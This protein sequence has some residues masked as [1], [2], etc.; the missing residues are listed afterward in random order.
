MTEQTQTQTPPLATLAING[1]INGKTSNGLAANG[2]AHM[3][4]SSS[5]QQQQQQH[6]DQ[7]QPSGTSAED[8][9]PAKSKR[10]PRGGFD[11]TELPDAPPGYTVRFTF[12]SA[13]NLA[14]G[15]LHT[16]SS[17]PFL[18][19]TLK[20]NGLKRHKED[21]D[22]THRTRT[23]CRTLEPVWDEAWTVANVPPTG[24]TLKCRLY[25]E[26]S[27]DK[28]DR[29]GNV[30]VR[31]PR[32]FRSWEGFPPPGRTFEG[33]KR[34][35]S[36]RAYLLKAVTDRFHRNHSAKH[37]SPL[38]TISIELLGESEPPHGQMYTVGPARW[39][40]H[41]SPM[42]GRLAGTKVEGDKGGA[43]A[44]AGGESA[45]KKKQQ[46]Q[47]TNGEANGGEASS[48]G[49]Q[50]NKNQRY[51]FRA[52]EMQ[53]V[54]P[55][56]PNMYHRFV[57]FR[58]IIGS[59]FMSTGIRG[60]ILNKALH[61]QHNRIYSFDSSTAC[62][63]FS[64]CTPAATEQFLQMAHFDEGGRV[65]TYVLTLDALLR[66][67]ETGKEFGIDLLSK[68]TMHSDVETYIA[69]SGEF[70]IRRLERPTASDDPDPKGRT[71]P[72][73]E[74]PGGPPNEPPPQD[75]AHYQLVIDND[76]G[77][78]RPDRSA[79]PALKEF[80]ERNLPGL[81]VV[82]MHWE[83]EELKEMKE[84][85]HRAKH[86]E[87][88]GR[89]LRGVLN[90]SASS[91]SSAE[92]ELEDRQAAAGDGGDGWDGKK[93]KR[94]KAWEALERPAAIKETAKQALP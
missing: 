61:K 3:N 75:P 93:S 73:D 51:E 44:G 65:F 70:F 7:Q 45:E 31:V 8:R 47:D 67:T 37:M 53:L 14:P 84:A 33:K 43:G 58:P 42:I 77:T 25:D 57:A 49:K 74:L 10:R 83:D 39:V 30:T 35:M 62:E 69:Y 22:L 55:V 24:F 81:G 90:R 46:Q 64:P 54:G 63:D 87:R 94:E 82:A 56:P 80:L 71:H 48:S 32:L 28:N 6:D 88:G 16:A 4:G 50:T 29:L 11:P 9:K 23:L 18:H 79:L 27:P 1:T 17:D 2:S 59:M 19:A 89:V 13:T 34:V 78:Y 15:D 36:K 40:Q 38:V 60:K 72:D 86:R 92:S 76:S 52:N 66:F 85:Q 12:H 5:K 68:H 26:D 91:I 21:P 20:V 41:F